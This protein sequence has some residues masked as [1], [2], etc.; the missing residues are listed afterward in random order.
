MLSSHYLYQKVGGE[1]VF[2]ETLGCLNKNQG[3]L[4]RDR[5]KGKMH[6]EN[7]IHK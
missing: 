5:I 2:L 4:K 3:L 6:T 7:K 1:P